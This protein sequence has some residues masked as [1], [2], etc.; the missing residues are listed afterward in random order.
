MSRGIDLT[1]VG[2]RR[3]DPCR[4]IG[5]RPER[6]YGSGRGRDRGREVIVGVI[7]LGVPIE[8]GKRVPVGGHGNRMGSRG[9]C[10]TKRGTALQ[11]M[12]EEIRVGLEDGLDVQIAPTG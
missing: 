6:R 7:G 2:G 9:S 10:W 1:K 11:E 4:L 8:I 3:S 5:G 12:E